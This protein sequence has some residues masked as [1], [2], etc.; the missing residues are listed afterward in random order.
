MKIILVIKIVLLCFFAIQ[1]ILTVREIQN[2]LFSDHENAWSYFAIVKKSN[3]NELLM[4]IWYK[5]SEGIKLDLYNSKEQVVY[6]HLFDKETAFK[7]DFYFKDKIVFETKSLYCLNTNSFTLET[8]SK[9]NIK[10]KDIIK[11]R[12]GNKEYLLFYNDFS[13]DIYDPETNKYVLSDQNLNTLPAEEKIIVVSNGQSEL[14]AFNLISKT[15]LWNYKLEKV[16]IYYL[17]IKVGSFLDKF[18][19]YFIAFEKQKK[20]VIANSKAGSLYKFDYMSGTVL[21]SKERFK[22]TGNNAGLM[23]AVAY[24]DMNKDGIIDIIGASVDNNIYCIDGKDFSE[25]WSNNTGDENQTPCSLVDLNDDN[26]PEIFSVNNN[27]TLSI[28]NGNNGKLI[29]SIYLKDKNANTNFQTRVF[30]ADIN[31]NS[32]LDAIVLSGTNRIKVFEINTKRVEKNSLVW[33][34]SY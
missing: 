25:I 19:S 6:S 8:I 15:K 11:K 7:N 4:A 29:K 34:P 2:M 26:I 1:E 30:L 18:K 13:L 3:Q 32:L 17:G 24:H 21:L 27:M 16:P 22:G 5:N 20:I 12:I 28:I 10:Y 31:G 14:N 33:A 9:P 23:P